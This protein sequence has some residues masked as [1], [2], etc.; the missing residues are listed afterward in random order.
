MAK[1]RRHT[2]LALSLLLFVAPGCAQ[3]VPGYNYD[4]SK[5]PP[6]TLLDPLR[7]ADGH[8]VTTPQQWFTQRRPE[9]L[10]LFEENICGVTP[11]AAKNAITHARIIEH[12]EHALNGLAVREQV[13]LTFE[14]APG[15]TPSPQTQRTIRLLISIPAAPAATPTPHPPLT[16][17]PLLSAPAPAA[18]AHYPVP[19]VLG[20]NFGGNQTVLDDPAILPRPIWTQPKGATE[21][22]RIAP[23]DET[24]GRSADQWQVKMLLS[25]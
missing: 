4:E 8:T 1:A 25:R 15:V 5:I 9:I 3:R 21:L 20:L 18:A 17:R 7:L 22:Q 13:D 23:S 14:P 12:N 6:H 24:R 10:R 19:V 11:A 2:L 16:L